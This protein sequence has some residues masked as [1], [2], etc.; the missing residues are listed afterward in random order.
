[1]IV[2][3]E[4]ILFLFAVYRGRGYEAISGVILFLGALV[5]AFELGYDSAVLIRTFDA[6]LIGALALL[7]IVSKKNYSS[8]PAETDITI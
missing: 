7:G 1:M 2:I 8:E 3:A 4:I 5:T 6:V